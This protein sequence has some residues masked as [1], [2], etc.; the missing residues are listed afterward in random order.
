MSTWDDYKREEYSNEAL[1]GKYRC[2]I[3]D[4]EEAISKSSNLPMIV[5]TV[6]PSG[7]K[8]KVKTYLVK[9]E[10]FNQN[11][12][13][14]FDSFPEIEEG[15]F[16]F[17]SWIGCEG[18]AMFGEDKNGYTALKYFISASRA[19]SLPPFE[20]EKPERQTVTTLDEEEGD[21]EDDDDFPFV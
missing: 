17:I 3:V 19:E 2:V 10:K 11:A 15:D 20:G 5:I 18:A 4:V 16:N 8:F 14:F 13:S 9:N 6:R 1:V 12:T 7:S 21:P